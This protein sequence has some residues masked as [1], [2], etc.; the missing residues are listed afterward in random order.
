MTLYLT[1]SE[2]FHLPEEEVERFQKEY[3]EWLHTGQPCCEF[4]YDKG[5]TT[6]YLR[7]DAI[8][9]REVRHVATGASPGRGY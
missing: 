8:M 4:V 3:D 9:R 6:H 5:H 7:F 1:G 2:A